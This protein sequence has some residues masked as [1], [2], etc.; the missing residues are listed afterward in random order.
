VTVIIVA[1]T[2]SS[3]RGP[4]SDDDAGDIVDASPVE[5]SDGAVCSG[6]GEVLCA[7]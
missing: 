5:T 4:G 3:G 2:T 6:P 7:G 1:S